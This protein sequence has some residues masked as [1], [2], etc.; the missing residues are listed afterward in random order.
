M[1]SSDVQGELELKLKRQERNLGDCYLNVDVH[2]MKRWVV[3]VR[4]YKLLQV[5]NFKRPT[6]HLVANKPSGRTTRYLVAKFLGRKDWVVLVYSTS[7]GYSIDIYKIIMSTSDLGTFL[8][9]RRL[10]IEPSLCASSPG[11]VVSRHLVDLPPLPPLATDYGS[12]YILTAGT[13]SIHMWDVHSWEKLPL[14]DLP[15]ITQLSFHPSESQIFA[16]GRRGGEI[17]LHDH[18]EWSVL[19]TDEVWESI[20]SMEFGSDERKSL[21][22]TG[23]SLGQVQIWDYQRRECLSTL[24]V[25]EGLVDVIALFHP[26]RPYIMCALDTGVIKVYNDSDYKPV[27]CHR[28]GL[29]RLQSMAPYRES[30]HVILGGKGMFV[31]M[32]ADHPAKKIKTENT[33]EQGTEDSAAAHKQK[34]SMPAKKISPRATGVIDLTDETA[35]PARSKHEKTEARADSKNI[36]NELNW[37]RGAMGE[38]SDQSGSENEENVV[39]TDESN[40]MQQT[41]TPTERFVQ[42]LPKNKRKE[43]EIDTGAEKKVKLIRTEASF[44]KK[45]FEES[46]SQHVKQEQI[47][48]ERIE[49]FK[50]EVRSLAAKEQALRARCEECESQ[51]KSSDKLHAE[52]VKRLKVKARRLRIESAGLREGLEN[53]KAEI[54]RLEEMY[55]ESK[56]NVKDLECRL[57]RYCSAGDTSEKYVGLRAAGNQKDRADRLWEFASQE[58]QAATN[59][60]DDSCKLEERRYADFYVGKMSSVM[61]KQLKAGNKILWNQHGKLTREMMDRLKSLQH[62]HLQTFLGVCYENN[63]LVYEHMANGSVKDRIISCAKGGS[64]RKSLSWDV[65]LRVIAQVAHALF[66]LHSNQS[67]AGGPIIHRG[68]K[69]ENIFLDA[70]LVAK[71]GE[72]EAALL[73]PERASEMCM[74]AA[75]SSLQYLAPEFCQSNGTFSDEKTDIYSFG[76]TVLEILSGNFTDAV[77][78]LGKAFEESDQTL[79]SALDAKAGD[80]DVD[81]VLKAVELGL[82]CADLDSRNRPSMKKGEDAIL[83]RLD[84]IVSKVKNSVPRGRPSNRQGQMGEGSGG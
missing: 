83:V 10:T 4:D 64:T 49:E 6:C 18:G 40:G 63:C 15:D 27:A 39:G 84:D 2:P 31:V 80:W 13:Y 3:F 35:A 79:A 74:S 16:T 66:F 25:A 82:S 70:N 29:R 67:V 30:N 38:R 19:R 71:I 33:S 26:L 61:I 65:R 36:D 50:N 8:L 53:S 9:Q 77:R 48:A 54:K 24:G 44:L 7:R 52:T 56:V 34:G 1:A 5:W 37:R 32:E 55:E 21:L 78:S 51:K 45:G 57:Q 47:H 46:R 41:P 75:K 23:N 14:P 17:R 69:P 58:L 81:L 20:T 42:P 12:R 11:P 68:I 28:T 22:I 73:A 60:F 72:V 62:S 43:N 76:V 59:S